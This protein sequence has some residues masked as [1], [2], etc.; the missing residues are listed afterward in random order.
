[1]VY[2]CKVRSTNKYSDDEDE[3][4]RNHGL[5]NE[6]P[7]AP[8]DSAPFGRPKRGRGRPR[9]SGAGRGRR[10]KTGYKG[11]GGW[12]KGTKS[13]P[14]AALEP[15]EEFNQLH[16]EATN[17]FIDQHDYE[18]AHR[19]VLEA[20]KLNPEVYSAH[21]LLSEI[22]FAKGDDQKAV[23][24]LFAGAHAASRERE[25]WLQLVDVTLQRSTTDRTAA[26]ERAEYCYTKMIQIDEKDF[27]A[28]FE[29]AGIRQQLGKFTKSLKDLEFLLE[30]V[31]Y[32]SSVMRRIAEVCIEVGDINKA[33]SLYEDFLERTLT[34]GLAGEG[35]FS[36]TEVNV[37]A[38]LITKQSTIKDGVI[39]LRRLARWLLGREAES[40]WDDVEDDREWDSFDDPRRLLVA[41]YEAGMFPIETYGDGLPLELRVR[42]G[43]FRLKQELAFRSEA[44]LHF[45][46]LEPEMHDEEAIVY[47][48]PDL[49]LEV[50][51]AL[52][53]VKEHEQALRFYEALKDVGA[54]SNTAFWLGIAT[55]SV[56]CG[57]R[58]QAIECYERAKASDEQCSE[59]RTQLSKLYADQGD[60]QKATENARQ[61][62][63]VAQSAVRQTAKRRYERKDQRLAR[64]A[65]EAA[66]RSAYKLAAPRQR[67]AV[68][69]RH[70]LDK[71]R[72]QRVSRAP[73]LLKAKAR[74]EEDTKSRREE[75]IV[76]LYSTLENNT[77][78]MRAGDMTAQNIWMDCAETM[79][80]DFRTVRPFYPPERHMKFMGYDP[81]AYLQAN[82][83]KST[84][85]VSLESQGIGANQAS[86]IDNSAV[87][88]VPMQSIEDEV[89]TDYCGIPFTKWLDIFLEYALLLANSDL[90][91]A[92]PRCY[93]II[94]AAQDCVIWYHEAQPSLQIYTCQFTCA[95]AL[96]D[97]STLFS[98]SLR[99]FMRTYRFSTDAYRLFFALNLVYKNKT[100]KGDRADN[101]HAAAW[102]YGSNEKFMLRQIM[103]LDSQL[104][105]DY[106]EQGVPVPEFMRHNQVSKD[107]QK[108]KQDWQLDEDPALN[109]PASTKL[110]PKEMDVLLLVLYGQMLY[111]SNKG[112]QMA[113]CYFYRAYAL[114]PKNPV[115]LLSIALSYM[116]H[117]TSR[118]ANDR[119]MCMLN[120]LAF[121]E[122]YADARLAWARG[123]GKHLEEVVKR[124]I[125]FNRARCWHMMGMSDLAVRGYEKMLDMPLSEPDAGQVVERYT[126]EAAYAMS[127][128]YAL[129]G[130]A[131]T[132]RQI[133]E[134]WLVVD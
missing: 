111:A 19:L 7:H 30:E 4:S 8:E 45:E 48:Y 41:E 57:K 34:D 17:A 27:E 115:V 117:L 70:G 26:L 100:E 108:Q 79:I 99:W 68:S 132:A 104:P 12:N 69:T 71:S 33:K 105:D 127:T 110:K 43:L 121:L 1:M 74:P 20:L 63:L 114:D 24:A 44:L 54:F 116:H 38:D 126:M 119:H 2:T 83:R 107:W 122:E 42:L 55:S 47:V 118:K 89:P 52:N 124:E 37:Y 25:V 61:A 65:A 97:D 77:A 16:K 40:Y 120:G 92:Q 95:L 32:H 85:P 11:R 28:H 46:W 75:N 51:Q 72:A 78:G 87:Q 60:R 58:E 94:K 98:E 23:D 86:Q 14:R 123:K 88:D 102:Q 53:E 39:I 125:E 109:G 73:R 35:S 113:L 106:T 22:L 62:L 90:D 56:I 93:T 3:D 49:F 59:A 84:K 103:M 67:A 112:F 66:L 80:A 96:R 82:R 13:G 50:A 128:M 101:L 21:A 129:S 36:W 6:V 10:H 81:V 18:Q 5:A 133:A 64:E 29:R 91:D 15:S 9:G 76:Q 131:E 134:K 31:P 130:D